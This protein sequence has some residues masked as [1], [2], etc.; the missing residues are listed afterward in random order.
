MLRSLNLSLQ[1]FYNYRLSRHVASHI[2]QSSFCFILFYS[3]LAFIYIHTSSC[4][5]FLFFICLVHA[6]TTQR[7]TF[8]SRRLNV[9]VFFFFSFLAYSLKSH[10][11]INVFLFCLLQFEHMEYTYT[12]LRFA[13]ASIY[14]YSHKSQ[15]YIYLHSFIACMRT[16]EL[17]PS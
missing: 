5:L 8:Y 3:P 17:S 10:V 13:R 2:H 15:T 1:Y 11:I 6:W 7:D 14:L 12:I 9:T 16:H 4:F